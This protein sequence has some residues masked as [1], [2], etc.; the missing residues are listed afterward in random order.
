MYYELYLDRMFLLHFPLH[1]LLLYL[2][3]SMMES[4]VKI[5]RLLFV[6]AVQTCFYLA[7]FALPAGPKFWPGKWLLFSVGTLFC[8]WV[9]FHFSAVE[10]LIYAGFRYIAAA[11]YLGGALTAVRAGNAAADNT[12]A[13]ILVT[14]VAA[15]AA[16][17][18]FLNKSRKKSRIPLWKVTV[19]N[20]G[21]TLEV[22]A[23]MDSG[24]SLYDPISQKPVCIVT[25]EVAD[26]LK[27]FE[28]P[29][30]FRAIPYHTVGEKQGV[31]MA[32]AADQ[33]YLQKG[34]QKLFRKQVILAVSRQPLSGAGQYQMLLH[35]AILEEKLP[36]E[37]KRGENY[38]TQSRSAGKDAV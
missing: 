22:T 23:L 35:P 29:E 34:E 10:E 13:G 32:A 14:A 7:V 37:K 33:M 21:R 8:L 38:D 5:R 12:V 18:G 1:F 24:N 27:L 20:G 26:A 17:V 9:S 31:L 28:K 15:A 19:K 3:N 30:R 4:T 2:T 11:I 25:G 36:E 6:S 16:V